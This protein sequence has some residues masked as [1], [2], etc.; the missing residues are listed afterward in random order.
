MFEY[1]T[2]IFIHHTDA[3][4]RLFFANQFYLIHE[5]K[6]KFLEHLGLSIRDILEHPVASFPLVHAESD[7]KSILTAGDRITIYVAIERIGETSVTFLF[8]ILK[9]DGS[10]AGTSK[11]VSVAVDRK[12]FTKMPIPAEWRK[13]L[14][15]SMAD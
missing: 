2:Q 3:A 1:K 14:E 11:T 4:G 9:A 5:A 7:Y 6:E 15:C 13:K 8:S 12:T 10:L